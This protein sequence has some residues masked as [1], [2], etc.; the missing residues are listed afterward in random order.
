MQAGPD[1]QE[2]QHGGCAQGED[3]EQTEGLGH[4]RQFLV[5]DGGQ[6]GKNGAVEGEE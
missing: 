3:G 6:T 1:D 5:G 4:R 2:Q